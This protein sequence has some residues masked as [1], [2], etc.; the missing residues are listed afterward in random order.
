[1]D[2]SNHLLLSKIKIIWMITI[3]AKQ[4]LNIKMII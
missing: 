1:M 4:K 3:K 2:K